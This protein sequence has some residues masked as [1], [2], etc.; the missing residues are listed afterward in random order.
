MQEKRNAR[1]VRVIP[2]YSK[3][4]FDWLLPTQIRAI[5]TINKKMRTISVIIS[6]AITLPPYYFLFAPLGATG[7]CVLTQSPVAHY[8]NARKHFGDGQ[9]Q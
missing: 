9:P 4:V 5:P 7:D 6:F 8:I 2:P 3:V 1:E